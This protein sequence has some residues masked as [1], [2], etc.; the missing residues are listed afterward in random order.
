MK[1]V[2]SLVFAVL[3][4]FAASYDLSAQNDLRQRFEKIRDEHR[5]EFQSTRQ[6]YND[7]FAEFVKR[8]WESFNSCK[9]VSKPKDEMVPPVEYDNESKPSPFEEVVID[10]D[11]VIPV[12]EIKEQP[13]PLEPVSPSVS[14]SAD[15]RVNF[16]YLGA[17]YE[18]PAGEAFRLD[19]SNPEAVS[20]AWLKLG[21]YDGM[22]GRCLKIRDDAKLC[23]WA[24]LNL[25]SECASACFEQDDAA[26]L[27]LFYL[28]SQSGY[29]A[30]LATADGHLTVLYGSDYVVYDKGFF[31]IDGHKF[32]AWKE[33]PDE[34][35]VCDFCF[36]NEKPL[37]LMMSEMPVAGRSALEAREFRSA[38]GVYATTG[39][40]GNLIEYMSGYPCSQFGDDFMTKW[41]L[42]ANA[43]MSES[44]KQSLYP[45][46]RKAIGGKSTK[47][48]LNILLNFVQTAFEYEY[49]EKVWGGDRVFFAEESLFYPYCDCEDRSILFS[50]LVR[51]L[52]SL[53][54]VL[55]HY[56]GHL[57]TAVAVAEDIPGDRLT[58]RDGRYLVCDPT[59]IGAPIGVTMKGM[60]NGEATLIKLE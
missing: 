54:V 50:R 6:K 29:R 37:S 24:Y 44:V 8:S 40:N 21:S 28:Y 47:D 43:P 36:P 16:S 42:Y 15:K 31:L 14:P 11:N 55:V 10:E 38:S 57:A 46:L 39:I 49:D 33:E 51:D 7:R 58:T 35:D 2:F 3:L 41:S 9:P 4:L 34:L 25:L 45:Y 5:Q 23:D 22:L 60:D 59:Y 13:Q 52:L 18:V 1:R 53:D 12:P 17:D 26:A 32:Y 20:E 56:P 30:R 19:S 48:A 27:L